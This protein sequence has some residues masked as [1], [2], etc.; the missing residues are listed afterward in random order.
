M[1]VG[2]PWA[3][4][5]SASGDLGF[6]ASG[7]WVLKAL[8]LCRL[9]GVMDLGFCFSCFK[10]PFLR[11]F[12]VACTPKPVYGRQGLGV[13]GVGDLKLC[14]SSVCLRALASRNAVGYGGPVQAHSSFLLNTPYSTQ[15]AV[16]FIDPKSPAPPN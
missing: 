1:G 12:V 6:A 11:A 10:G 16:S 8:R 4:W 9:H 15:K 2:V 13:Q 3:P 14:R 7:L 5:D